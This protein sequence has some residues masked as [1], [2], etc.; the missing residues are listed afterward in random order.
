MDLS[1]SSNEILYL[2]GFIFFIPSIIAFRRKA[3]RRIE[4]CEKKGF[5]F[6]VFTSF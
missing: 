3:K 1:F 2:E 4:V 5:E 6:E